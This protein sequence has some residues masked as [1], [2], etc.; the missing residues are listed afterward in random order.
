MIFIFIGTGLFFGLIIPTVLMPAM[1]GAS[2]AVLE[3]VRIYSKG[4]LSCGK[5]DYVTGAGYY[6]RG[7]VYV[8]TD[9]SGTENFVSGRVFGFLVLVFMPLCVM[10]SL[11]VYAAVF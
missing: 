5:D 10:L 1:P 6:R 2:I 9:E 3:L 11:V 7:L 8:H 4:S